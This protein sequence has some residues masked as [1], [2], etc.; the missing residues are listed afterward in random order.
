MLKE[1][2]IEVKKSIQLLVD[3]KSIINLA[4]NLVSH[5]RSKHIETKFHFLQ[6]QLNHGRIEVVYYKTE[7]QVVDILTKSLE[8]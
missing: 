7:M 3:N 1:L 8:D 5:D 4:K 6:E 2:K